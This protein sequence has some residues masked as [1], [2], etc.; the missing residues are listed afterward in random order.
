MCCIVHQ[1]LESHKVASESKTLEIVV[2]M[3]ELF[4]FDR[5]MYVQL[6]AETLRLTKLTVH[7][8]TMEELQ[9][10]K[11]HDKLYLNLT[12]FLAIKRDFNW[13]SAA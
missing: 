3:Q 6:I 12:Q 8:I 1:V 7:Q 9:M 10:R 5:Q 13:N 11:I 2:K 4:F